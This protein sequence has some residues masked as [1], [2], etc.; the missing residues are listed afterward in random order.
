[1]ASCE[2][3]PLYCAGRV[4]DEQN[5]MGADAQ[6][7][8]GDEENYED[9]S[10]GMKTGQSTPGYRKEGGRCRRRL[11][12]QDTDNAQRRRTATRSS[13]ASEYSLRFLALVA[14]RQEPRLLRM[15]SQPTT[16]TNLCRRRSRTTTSPRTRCPI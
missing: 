5:Q 9:Y 13:V 8:D 14:D 7:P 4:A 1:M 3:V 6:A 15:S 11:L 12:L 10:S 2:G 16:R